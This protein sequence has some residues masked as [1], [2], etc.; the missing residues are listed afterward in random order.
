MGLA[1]Q[2]W[3]VVAG[4]RGWLSDGTMDRADRSLYRSDIIFPGFIPADQGLFRLIRDTDVE[5]RS[6]R[7][8]GSARFRKVSHSALG[9]S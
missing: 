3:L 7:I 4:R 9:A 1:P 2:Y 6:V 8:G 5:F